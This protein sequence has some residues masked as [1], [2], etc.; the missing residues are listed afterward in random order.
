MEN[1]EAFKEEE[2]S[3]S[4]ES[5]EEGDAYGEPYFSLKLVTPYEE[6]ALLSVKGYEDCL[7]KV[8]VSGVVVSESR[9]VNG[10]KLGG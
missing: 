2:K 6:E 4:V 8:W 1:V 5:L 3:F 9:F 10:K 7:L